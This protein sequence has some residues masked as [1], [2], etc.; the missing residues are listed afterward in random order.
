M[1]HKNRPLAEEE[2][3]A[4]DRQQPGKKTY[5]RPE[6]RLEKVFET[7]ALACVKLRST[8]APFRHRRRSC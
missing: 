7:M 2:K 1:T 5:Q 6:S 3:S 8:G 4:L